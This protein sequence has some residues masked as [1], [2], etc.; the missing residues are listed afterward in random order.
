VISE[1]TVETHVSRVIA[2]LGVPNRAAVGRALAARP[3]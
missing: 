3:E 2:K 1:K